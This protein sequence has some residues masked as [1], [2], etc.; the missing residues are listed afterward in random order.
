MTREEHLAWCKQRALEYVE[1]GDL[2]NA[3]MSMLS[4]LNKHDE[5]ANH[6]GMRLGAML[7]TGGHLQTQQQM[8]NFITGFN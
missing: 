1:R 5:T 8:R 3:F 2:T 7:L 4:D 6:S